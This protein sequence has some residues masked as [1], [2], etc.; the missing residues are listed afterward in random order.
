MNRTSTLGERFAEAK[1]GVKGK[2]LKGVKDMLYTRKE[3]GKALGRAEKS[4]MQLEDS[5]AFDTRKCVQDCTS[6]DP[7]PAACDLLA[8]VCKLSFKWQHRDI[9]MDKI[10]QVLNL[11]LR[12]NA[13]PQN[14]YNPSQ[15]SFLRFAPL[16]G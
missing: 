7:K 4:G 2:S 10:F 5:D 15:N 6:I 9:I 12:V 11:R 14:I 3:N 1:K 16:G 13:L 8:E